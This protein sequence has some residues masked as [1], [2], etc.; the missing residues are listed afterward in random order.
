MNL[1]LRVKILFNE[2][3]FELKTMKWSLVQ[4]RS[5][6]LVMSSF[7]LDFLAE[8]EISDYRMFEGWDGKQSTGAGTD[9]INDNVFNVGITWASPLKA[10]T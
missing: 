8:Q 4:Q 3:L 7:F 1:H 5:V 6:K 9:P 2:F 10:G